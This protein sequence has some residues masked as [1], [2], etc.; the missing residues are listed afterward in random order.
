MKPVED[1]RLAS[2]PRAEMKEPEGPPSL[3][4][5]GPDDPRV[6][7]ALEEYLAALEAGHRPDRQE[8]LSRHA[9]IA[10]VLAGCL[11]GLEFM[12]AANSA[13][14]SAAGVQLADPATT[15]HPTAPLGDFCL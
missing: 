10:Q 4:P 2:E 3:S 9:A 11:D 12:Q 7:R 13:R 14:Q 1:A 8:F 5:S 15:L 6:I